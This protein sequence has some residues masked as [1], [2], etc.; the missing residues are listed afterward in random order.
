MKSRILGCVFAILGFGIC[1]QYSIAEDFDWP[2]W[3]GPNGDGISMETDWDPEALKD[4]PRILWKIKV[5]MGH[6]NMAIK[7]KYIYTLG[8][9]GRNREDAVYCL[10]T[11]T[12]EEIWRYTY[13]SEMCNLGTQTTPT[14]DGKLLYTLS[15]DGQVHC[16]NSRNGKLRWKKDLVNDLKSLESEYGFG[17]SPVVVGDLVI[18]N[19]KTSG[20]ALNKKTGDKIWEGEVNTDTE[21]AY[22][23]T[24]V[25]Y[26]HDDR[27]CVLFFSDS[28]LFSMDVETG[29][30]SWFYEWT[31]PG[32]PNVA[33]PLVFDNKVFLSH[34]EIHARCVLLDI[35][36]KE[37]TVLWENE[38]LRNH[39]STSIYIDG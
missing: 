11:N 27:Q 20:I 19:A 14:I 38:N 7:G 17:T 8:Y 4:S 2:R 24:P 10:N 26:E 12:G 31:Q 16:F 28:G 23:A 25:I 34:S 33:D 35:S 21:G 15:A 36:G 9:K 29:K 1:T 32:A 39:V 3:R 6:S 22:F 37:P 18:L 30:L 13:A 5:G